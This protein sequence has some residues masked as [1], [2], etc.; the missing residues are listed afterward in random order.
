MDLMCSFFSIATRHMTSTPPSSS[1]Q[2]DSMPPLQGLPILLVS[3]LTASF[4][5]LAWL[6]VKPRVL[7][8]PLIS[9]FILCQ[10]NGFWTFSRILTITSKKLN[11]TV[12]YIGR[13]QS[14]FGSLAKVFPITLNKMRV[15]YHLI[16][17][18]SGRELILSGLI[19]AVCGTQI[20]GTLRS[21]KMCHSFSKKTQNI[22]ANYIHHLYDSANRIASL[23]QRDHDMMFFEFSPISY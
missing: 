13:P 21:F 18:N 19:V 20:I 2:S 10:Q 4:S 15:M 3:I 5:F 11:G 1:H 9:C 22:F 6:K 14:S 7:F 17:S 12:I 23:K 8:L 16:M